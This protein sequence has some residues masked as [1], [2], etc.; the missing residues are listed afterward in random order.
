[1]AAKLKLMKFLQE[2]RVQDEF[3]HRRPAPRSPLLYLIQMRS[4]AHQVVVP[5]RRLVI[6]VDLIG[7]DELEMPVTINF[8]KPLEANG[9]DPK[10]I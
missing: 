5:K 9:A 1:M 2:A 4:Q 3:T 7:N 8:P 6:P 10:L